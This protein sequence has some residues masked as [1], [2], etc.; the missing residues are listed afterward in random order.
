[1]AAKRLLVISILILACINCINS[2]P[3]DDYVNTP[4]PHYEYELVKVYE[5]IGAKVRSF[6]NSKAPATCSERFFS[7]SNMF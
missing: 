4:D 2:T 7:Q 6:F 1:M 5:A 3:L